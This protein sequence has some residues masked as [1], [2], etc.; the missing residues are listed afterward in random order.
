M[1]M[2]S[3]YGLLVVIGRGVG[4][5]MFQRSALSGLLMLVGIFLNSWEMGVLAIGGNV[6]ST[7][8][9][10]LSGY[11]R[12]EIRDGLYGFNGTLV[13]IAV[14]VFMRLSVVS[15][16]LMAVGACVST[17]IA[18]LFGWQRIVPGF[19]APFIVSVWVLLGFCSW[20]IPDVLPASDA[21]SGV[22]Q[23]VDCVRS[24]GCGVGQV[25]F[26]GNV[27]SGLL[28]L[29]AVFV[30]SR[31]GAF[32]AVWGALLPVLFAVVPGVE[33]DVVNMGLLGYNGVLCAIA[34]GER[35]WRGLACASVAVL[36]SV[37][38]Q[39]GGMWLGVTTLTAPFVVAVWMVMG[40]RW[41]VS[42]WS[43][44]V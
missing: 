39:L 23:G 20:V 5:V 28:F 29:A 6:A 33:A 35:S 42:R 22:A 19:T 9:A 25:M 7:L 14:G 17:W 10:W 30:N 18:R 1:R 43:G 4:Q 21:A 2:V 8:T 12:E 31:M 15:V 38:L 26:Q 32:Y 44:V 13:G 40:V 34:L 41:L 16:L 3:V 37:G 36:L 11:K 24:L 27:W